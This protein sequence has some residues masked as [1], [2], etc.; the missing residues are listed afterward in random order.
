MTEQVT[1]SEAIMKAVA[2]ATRIAIQT[3]VETQA[4]RSESQ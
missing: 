1:T 3:M 2:D 4:Q